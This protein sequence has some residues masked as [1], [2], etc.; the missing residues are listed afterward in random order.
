MMWTISVRSSS[1]LG[2]HDVLPRGALRL[3][4]PGG[5]AE[6]PPSIVVCR[7]RR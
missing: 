7:S 3:S 1:S 6:V 5:D 2:C 4:R